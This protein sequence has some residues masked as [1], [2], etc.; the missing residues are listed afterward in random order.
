VLLFSYNS[1]SYF[2]FAVNSK[3]EDDFTEIA[4]DICSKLQYIALARKDLVRYR[5]H[6]KQLLWN[7]TSS[8]IYTFIR[9]VNLLREKVLTVNRSPYILLQVCKE[10]GLKVR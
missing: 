4:G 7:G 5:Y 10:T 6:L 1:H 9:C 8:C 3:A 2:P